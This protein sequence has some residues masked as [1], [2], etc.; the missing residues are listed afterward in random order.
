[1]VAVSVG[2]DSRRRKTNDKNKSIGADQIERRG[3]NNFKRNDARSR[4]GGRLS[5]TDVPNGGPTGRHYC[6]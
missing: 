5:R 2:V 1:M 3:L 4:I 6:L